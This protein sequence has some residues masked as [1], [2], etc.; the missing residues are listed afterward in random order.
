MHQ[1]SRPVMAWL[2]AA[3]ALM[4]PPCLAAE[5][6]SPPAEDQGWVDLF[7]GKTLGGWKVTEENPDTFLVEQ[8][9]IKAAGGRAHLFYQPAG[10]PAP[11][12]RN[13]E[14]KMDVRTTS[15]SNS[16]IYFHTEY[17]PTGWP[18]KGYE[19]Q[20]NS[21]HRDWR[22]TGSLYA[23][24][25]VREVLV[26]DAEWYQ[27]HIIVNGKQITLRINGKTA[28][29]FTEPTPP[30]PPENMQGRFLSDGTFALQAH[31]PRSVVY[32]R[33]IRLKPLE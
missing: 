17:Q 6:N 12:F 31:D 5:S 23:I 22:K 3:V 19:A 11:Q 9:A 28:V 13:F 33:N 29:E 20:I 25:D 1:S 32:F 8:G 7:D 18:D 10:A 14:L 26:P 24:K 15:G 30:A 21:T 16:G 2:L 4:A 27:S